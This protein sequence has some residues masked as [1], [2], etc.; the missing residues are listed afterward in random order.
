MARASVKLYANKSIIVKANDPTSRFEVDK[1]AK[2][3]L[4]A[5]SSG[6]SYGIFMLL[7][8]DSFPSALKNQRL[9]EI[10]GSFCLYWGALMLSALKETFDPDTVTW[11]TK[12]DIVLMEDGRDNYYL[13]AGKNDQA[14]ETPADKTLSYNLAN[15]DLKSQ[16]AKAFLTACA[17]QARA[18]TTQY[19]L[20]VREMLVAG[21][22]PY[23][24][25]FY[26]DSVTIE[27]QIEQQNSPID[28]YVNPRNET[29]F[30]WDYVS[31]DSVYVCAGDFTQ[32]SA[33][34]YWKRSEDENYSDISISGDTKS[35]TVP[36]NTF[37]TGET[38]EW[39]LEGTDTAG[40]TS[41]TEVYSFSTTAGAAT[42]TL[43]SPINSVEDGTSPIPIVWT[44]ASDDGQEPI[45]VDLEWRLA[46][47]DNWTSLLS[48]AAA[49]TEYAAPGG[50][51]SSGEVQLRV[52]AYNVDDVAGEWSRPSSTT[53]YSFVCVAAPDP[54]RG[55]TATTAPMTT[56]RWQST[57]QQGYE[58]TI[59]GTVVA[60][61]YGPSVMQWKS[62]TP[63]SDGNHV[64][65]VR[66]QGSYSLWSQP[67]SI[68][69]TIA[70]SV[71]SEWSDIS[72]AGAFAVD[73]TL[74]LVY[75]NAD[76]SA[77]DIYWYR[78][79]KRI[80][81][82]TGQTAFVDRVVLG[83]HS[84]YAELWDSNGN[85]MRTNSVT[86]TMQTEETIIGAASG[87]E[88]VQLLLS[89]NSERVQTF[90]YKRTAKQYQILG[91]KYPVLE[92]SE[93][94]SMVGTCEC[95]FKTIDDAARFESLKGNIVIL[96]S[97]SGQVIIG[98]LLSV[99]KMV[100]TFYVSYSCSIEQIDWED[101]IRYD[102]TN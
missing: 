81:W 100:H 42:A 54:V 53:Y 47:N 63:L 17:A 44:L 15:T 69:V 67:T 74:T 30:A 32:A 70:N 13:S 6:T 4:E 56:V 1:N 76:L 98:G 12:P 45:A 91:S 60:S 55:L 78:D 21:T 85:Y 80:G 75:G 49:T 3:Y 36:S 18:S 99:Q 39:Y 10:K 102:T 25:V 46:G 64:I 33:V 59:D 24:E 95:A 20:Y 83:T 26:D 50:T 29:Q 72:L 79:S 88:W 28:G 40:T 2:I 86:G 87:G 101:F 31:A 38:I 68:T 35:L 8:F 65:S 92:L 23:I 43:K 90:Q 73:A 37:P 58:I 61:E 34:L 48:H 62:D 16:N 27:S 11:E 77:A 66:V 5:A 97:R 52:R 93:F 9:Y 19:S 96:K 82:T 7:G 51:F 89:E 57:G 84:Y 14:P 41:Q 71:P 22:E 94:E